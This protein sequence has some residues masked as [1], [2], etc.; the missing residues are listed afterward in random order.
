MTLT[1]F[2]M[3]CKRVWHALKK[4][5]KKEYWMIAKVSALGILVLG[6]I[7]FI[8]SMILEANLELSFP[9]LSF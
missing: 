8:L 6:I 7:G 5:G 1:S 9:S 4:P 2:F 3:K